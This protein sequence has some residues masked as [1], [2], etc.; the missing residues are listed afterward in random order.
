MSDM[1]KWKPER[2]VAFALGAG[3]V[4]LV[5]VFGA[6]LVGIPMVEAGAEALAV[7]FAALAPA[8]AAYIARS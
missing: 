7:I 5:L 4:V 8:V 2:K 3:L 1:E 6:A